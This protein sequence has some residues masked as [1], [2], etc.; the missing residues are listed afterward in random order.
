MRARRRWGRFVTLLVLLGSLSL[1]PV[2]ETAG[3]DKA[4]AGKAVELP[5]PLTPEAIR[6]L[7][8]R[9]SDAEVRQLLLGQLDKAAAPA[10]REDRRSRWRPGSRGTWTAART[11]I[12]AVLRAWPALPAAFG[13]AVRQFSEGR[14]PSPSAPG[15]RPLRGHAGAVVDRRAPGRAAARRR[16]GPARP[17]RGRGAGGSLLIRLALDLVTPGRLRRHV[18]RDLPGPLP[19][20]RAQPPC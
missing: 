6:E 17:G 19:G 16:P 20:P 13:D 8:A 14:E 12:G 5:E 10:G 18:D 2:P 4:A 15:R 7:V 11:Q 1:L 3:A 9:L